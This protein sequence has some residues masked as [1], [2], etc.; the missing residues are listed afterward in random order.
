MI[1]SLL[2]AGFMKG[3]LGSAGWICNHAK[4]AIARRLRSCR[5][6]VLPP[7]PLDQFDLVLIRGL[8]KTE[9]AA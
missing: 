3:P 4:R 1:E 5:L 9:P 7:G 8:D 2:S 6:S